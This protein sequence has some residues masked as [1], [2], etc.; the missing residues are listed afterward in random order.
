MSRR[1]GLG[2]SRLYRLADRTA[3]QEAHGYRKGRSRVDADDRA[4]DIVA[5]ALRPHFNAVV[6]RAASAS[7]RAPR[8]REAFTAVTATIPAE[9]DKECK[10]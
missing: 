4:V 3:G 6:N 5:R 1:F 7:L 2:V 10:G 9:R 8:L